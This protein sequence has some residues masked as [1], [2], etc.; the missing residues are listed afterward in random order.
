MC[1]YNKAYYDIFRGKLSEINWDDCFESD[2][3]NDVCTKWTDTFLA[4]DIED[5]PNKQV[6]IRPNDT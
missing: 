3:I 6:T 1:D 5:I 2:N 4:A